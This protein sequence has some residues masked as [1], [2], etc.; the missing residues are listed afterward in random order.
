MTPD[1]IPTEIRALRVGIKNRMILGHAKDGSR[2][3]AEYDAARERHIREQV[4]AEPIVARW[5]KGVVHHL[6]GTT[7]ECVDRDNPL[8]GIALELDLDDREALGLSLV[9]PDGVMDQADDGE[10][11]TLRDAWGEV[12]EALIHGAS[13]AAV[14]DLMDQHDRAAMLALAAIARQADDTTHP[15]ES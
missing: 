4:A 5:S 6:D 13:T 2:I 1:D 9:D 10:D 12:R 15:K 7:V 8:R 11:E 14:L 3:L